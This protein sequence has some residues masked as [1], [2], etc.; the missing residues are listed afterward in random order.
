MLDD[1][2]VKEFDTPSN[3]LANPASVFYGLAESANLL[4]LHTANANRRDE[5]TDL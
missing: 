3:L 4:P 5:E 1:G 2:F